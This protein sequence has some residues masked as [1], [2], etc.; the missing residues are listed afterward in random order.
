[1]FWQC[2]KQ[3]LDKDAFVARVLYIH[4]I[5]YQILDDNT[6]LTTPS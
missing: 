2:E 5:Y 3:S 4:G 6:D 1:M